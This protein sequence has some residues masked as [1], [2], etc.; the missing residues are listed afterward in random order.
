MTS[1]SRA[2]LLTDLRNRIRRL[3]DRTKSADRSRIDL[4]IPALEDWLPDGRL[5]AGSLV[6]L[7]SPAD[8]AGALTL[9]LFMS[10]HACWQHKV[11]VVVDHQGHFYP[12]AAARLGIDLDR[13]IVVHPR[14]PQD[15]ALAVDQSLRAAA[16]GSVLCWQDRLT[17]PAFRRLQLAAEIGG[18]LGLLLRPSTAQRAPSFAALR[19][20]VAPVASSEATRRIRLD[21]LR[22]RGGKTGQSTILEID[23]ATGNVRLPPHVA[24]AA[25]GARSAGASG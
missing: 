14:T 22:C 2:E 6:E 16:V 17:T 21:L 25:S 10:R 1:P 9:A 19:I 7:L 4:G 18:G 8:G 24:T 3:E 11:L 23:D 12:P 13:L 5:A 20:L 15:A